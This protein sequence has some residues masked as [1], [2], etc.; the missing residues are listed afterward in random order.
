MHPDSTIKILEIKSRIC[1]FIVFR[2]FLDELQVFRIC[3]KNGQRNKGYA[4]RLLNAA[5]K[6]SEKKASLAFLEVSSNNIP[7]LDLYKKNGFREAGIRNNYY[8]QGIHALN[9]TKE[10]SG[11]L[12]DCKDR[13]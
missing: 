11:G 12:N 8:G 9:M 6:K 2:I 3:C 5:F 10:L 4:T 13:N 7:A 1:G